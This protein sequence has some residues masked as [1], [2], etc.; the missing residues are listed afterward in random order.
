MDEKIVSGIVKVSRIIMTL[1]ILAT[2]IFIIRVDTA[3]LSRIKHRYAMLLTN[4][5]DNRNRCRI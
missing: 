4:L 3:G 5:L 1:E 2:E